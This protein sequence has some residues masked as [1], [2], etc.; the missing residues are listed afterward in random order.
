MNNIRPLKQLIEP[1][2]AMECARVLLLLSVSRHVSN[3]FYPF[4]LFDHFAF[5]YPVESSIRGFPMEPHRSIE[6]VIYIFKGSGNHH[7]KLGNAGLI[8]PK[9][10]QWMIAGGGILHEEIL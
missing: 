3:Q 4:L 7:D 9:D 6:T 1:Q 10:I 8:G 2:Y 5:N